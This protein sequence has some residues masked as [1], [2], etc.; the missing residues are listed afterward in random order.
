MSVDVKALMK[1]GGGLIWWVS[2]AFAGAC[3]S[4]WYALF[5]VITDPGSGLQA[6]WAC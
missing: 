1:W 4:A 6:W 3:A 2:L 5:G